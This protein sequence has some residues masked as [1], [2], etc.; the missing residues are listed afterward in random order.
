MRILVSSRREIAQLII[1]TQK[2]HPGNKII[3][4]SIVDPKSEPVNLPIDES[5]VLRLSF[6]DLDEKYPSTSPT[7][8]LFN[9]EMAQQIKEFVAQRLCD[10]LIIFS[11][12]EAG[13]SRSAGV[14]GALSKHFLGDDKDFFK[15]PY[16][17]NRLVYR[18]L[19]NL[20]NGQENS[21][22]ATLLGPCDLE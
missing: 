20:L 14:A 12:C 7:M 11:S 16:L 10:N 5:D 18:T 8:V 17:P 6:Y 13:I 9:Q 15:Y 3:T 19:L 4:I 21:V 1:K 2:D 22:P